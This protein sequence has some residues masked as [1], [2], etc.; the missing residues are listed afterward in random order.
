[1]I[2]ETKVSPKPKE[3]RIE[4]ETACTSQPD[5]EKP[6]PPARLHVHGI[7]QQLAGSSVPDD[8][9]LEHLRTG[10]WR[11]SIWDEL[12]VWVSYRRKMN[13]NEHRL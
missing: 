4:S 7:F 8:E 11:D 13:R 5:D 2:G 9:L 3:R 6:P 12:R 1:M 10:D